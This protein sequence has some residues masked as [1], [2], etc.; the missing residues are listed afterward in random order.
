MVL[1][2]LNLG[3][4]DFMVFERKKIQTETLNEYL[5][6]V[7]ANLGFSL[8][9]VSA[10]TGIKPKFLQTLENGDFSQLPADVYVL[11]FLG[12]LARLYAIDAEDLVRQYKK[13]KGIQQHLARETSLLNSAW[14]KKIL[15]KLVITPKILSLILGLAFIA[16]T[17]G[18]IIW[19]VWSIN[20]TPSLQIFSPQNNAVI[21]GAA[22]EVS[23]LTDPSAS[24]TINN[25]NVFVD[26]KGGF[27][28]QLG[29]SPGPKE[30]TVTAKN[31]FGKSFSR[32]LTVTAYS[33]SGALANR[34]ELKINFTSAVTLGF[35]IDDQQ[36]QALDFSSGD[37]KVFNAG[38]KILLS[39]SNAGATVITLNGQSLGP[40][41]RANEQLSNVPFL[42]ESK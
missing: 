18:Y 15:E 1:G 7:R 2:L 11:G 10:K 27:K 8:N 5:G 17:L 32:T 38:R 29:V 42:A 36:S 21:A 13:E 12:Q 41:G 40:M 6:A 19:Q 34:L 35:A 25:Q 31:R 26:S 9:E 23:G 20:K 39:T 22:V 37:T 4:Y 28:T 33:N 30:I 24:L 16:L 3:S 14:Y